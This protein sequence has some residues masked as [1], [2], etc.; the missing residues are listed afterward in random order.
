MTAAHP[1][2]ETAARID[3]AH[4]KQMTLGDDAL[5]REVLGLFDRQAMLMIERMRG[6]DRDAQMAMAHALK[7]SARGIG[8]WQVAE[9]A[10][11]FD[12]GGDAPAL[13]ALAASVAQVRAEIAQI[14]R[15]D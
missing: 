7:G 15:E 12:H 6:A 10:A 4:L 9:A 8:A 5:A 1:L 14:L 3:R 2:A 11:R 13:T